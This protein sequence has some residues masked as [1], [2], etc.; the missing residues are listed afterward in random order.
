[1]TTLVHALS[2]A[3]TVGF[4]YLG[5][6]AVWEWHRERT[7]SHAYRALAL[8]A[9]AVST[10]LARVEALAPITTRP[11]AAV[12]VVAFEVSAYALLLFRGTLTPLSPTFRNIAGS[13]LIAGGSLMVVVGQ[14]PPGELPSSLQFAAATIGILA[15]AA[16]ITEPIIRLWRVARHRPA[17]QRARLRALSAG[18]AGI[19]VIL[20][21]AIGIGPRSAQQTIGA[22]LGYGLAALALVPLLALTFV[23]PEWLRRRW[24]RRE[25]TAL[26]H[27][28]QALL[29]HTSDRATLAEL[30]LEWALRLVGGEGGLVLDEGGALLA[31]RG[32]GDEEL[33]AM[34]DG[35]APPVHATLV[36]SRGRGSRAAI[37]LPLQSAAGTATLIVLAGPVTPRFGA[38]E[39]ARLEEYADSVS[40]ALERVRLHEALSAVAATDA[41]TGLCNRGEFERIIEAPQGTPFA[42]LAIDVDRLKLINDTYG[43][44]AGDDALRAVATTLRMGVRDGDTL[45]RTGGDEFAAFLPGTEARDASAVAE[46]LRRSMYG[47]PL[48]HGVARISVGLAVGQCGD[49]A[50]AVWGQADEA[51]Y[52]AKGAGRDRCQIAQADTAAGSIGQVVRLET[53]LPSLL[54]ED[55]MTAVFQPVVDLVTGAIVGFEALGR[56]PGWG[57]HLGVDR[58][59][60]AAE[61]LG[62]GRDLDWIC[63]RAAVQRGADLPPGS[64]LFVNIG[65]TALLDPI[66][67]VDQMLLLLR[68]ARRKPSTVVLEITEREAVQDLDRLLEVLAAYREQ[69]FR[70]ALDDVGAG[71]STLE[72]L[73]TAVPEFVKISENLT[74]RASELGPQSAI[75]AVVAFAASCGGEVVAEGLENDNAVQLM[76]RLGVSLGQGFAL[77]RPAAASQWR[78]AGGDGWRPSVVAQPSL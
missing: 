38:E 50:A 26:R 68:W 32:P 2:Y 61:R 4:G 60:T 15:W 10:I 14:P 18:F 29:L 42:V 7:T 12:G 62:R 11:L 63:R 36:P 51:L 40:V 66:H 55:G 64:T 54:V 23:P 8:G 28:V 25:E 52:R 69:G 65:V 5:W 37:A 75:R 34:L 33:R 57:A 6:A 59:F 45:A 3:T 48:A 53:I 44:E 71:H 46:R 49:R 22:Q 31:R 76:R 47:V 30:A 17:I 74:S 20:L 43:H 72:V 56:P 21:V 70:F 41:L 19:V 77:G 67:G 39:V 24:R 78:R 73:A 13:A 58:L 9:L 27:A 1:M 35:S 16:C